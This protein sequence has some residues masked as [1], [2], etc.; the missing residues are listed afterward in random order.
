MYSPDEQKVSGSIRHW[1][2]MIFFFLPYWNWGQSNLKKWIPIYFP[3]KIKASRTDAGPPRL[4][5]AVVTWKCEGTITSPLRHIN[6]GSNKFTFCVR[7]HYRHIPGVTESVG[8]GPGNAE[9][10]KRYSSIFSNKLSLITGHR[11]WR[12]ALIMISSYTGHCLKHQLRCLLFFCCFFFLS[13]RNRKLVFFAAF[14]I[15]ML[16]HSIMWDWERVTAV[17]LSACC[18]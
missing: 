3:G 1:S 13:P 12:F 18:S 10:L 6:T 9:I 15:K 7:A 4:A 5:V 2:G 11:L 16:R 8:C 14:V 17:F